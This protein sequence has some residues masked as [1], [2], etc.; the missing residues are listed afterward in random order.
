MWQVHPELDPAEPPG[1]PTASSA[2]LTTCRVQ[3][4][5]HQNF[6]YFAEEDCHCNFQDR[7]LQLFKFS[8]NGPGEQKGVQ[9]SANVRCIPFWSIHGVENSI[10]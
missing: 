5:P 1:S 3:A 2:V 6:N 10:F 4:S 9:L 8:S 7:L